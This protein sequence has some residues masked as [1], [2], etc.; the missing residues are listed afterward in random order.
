MGHWTYDK[1]IGHGIWDMG[2]QM[3]FQLFERP[4][5]ST[6]ISNCSCTVA[7]TWSYRTSLSMIYMLVAFCSPHSFLNIF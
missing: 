3:Q 1:A 6:M 5:L 7:G 4:R 2:V